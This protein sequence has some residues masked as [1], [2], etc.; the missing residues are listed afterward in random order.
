MLIHR[1][2]T[3]FELIWPY[4]PLNWPVTQKQWPF[5]PVVETL[6]MTSKRLNGDTSLILQIAWI[7]I[8]HIRDEIFSHW[9]F[10][11]WWCK[12]RQS[13]DSHVT[14]KSETRFCLKLMSQYLW[15]FMNSNSY[16]YHFEAGLMAYRNKRGLWSRVRN[17]EKNSALF[18]CTINSALFLHYFTIH[19]Q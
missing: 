18:S 2:L 3:L 12:F 8:I 4:F 6:D 9:T 11:F 19:S 16:K 13:C 14:I 5:L 17:H 1:L 10:Y 15:I 7:I